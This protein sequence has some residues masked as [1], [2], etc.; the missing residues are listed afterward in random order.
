[1]TPKLQQ[2]IKLLQL[3]SVEVS[4]EI[5]PYLLENP[6]LEMDDGL[7]E[8][9]QAP[10]AEAPHDD[11]NISDQDFWDPSSDL[12][13]IDGP[14]GDSDHDLLMERGEEESLRGYIT[15]HIGLLFSHPGDIL[16][17]LRLLD[18]LD[19]SGYLVDDVGDI[20][21]QLGADEGDV[22]HVL[23]ILQ[24]L[25]PAGLFARTL[26]ECLSLQLRDQIGRAHV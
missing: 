7:F 5:A 2:A 22:L 23:E 9:P 15:R 19:A 10:S 20:A 12:S 4:A 8:G 25:E 11:L 1:M 17:A 26:A 6:L 21:Q 14:H 16:I 24:T 3:S 18:G 13:C